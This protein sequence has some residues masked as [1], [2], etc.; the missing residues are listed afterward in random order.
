[1]GVS[2]MESESSPIK[3]SAI[4]LSRLISS[5]PIQGGG[6]L[7]LSYTILQLLLEWQNSIGFSGDL[8]EV[9]VWRGDTL[10]LLATASV[11]GQKTIGVDIG[12]HWLNAARNLITE[13]CLGL[14]VE[15]EICC[16]QGSS[17]LPGLGALIKQEVGS[18]D[19]RF[20][21]IDGEHSRD[22]AISDARTIS[23]MMA[24]WGLICFDDCFL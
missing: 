12:E 7:T 8:L 19:I 5:G 17:T 20:A 3:A 16:I 4:F 6:A 24:P 10:T 18:A 13:T 9:G 23:P 21:H 22:L 11:H 2:A 14:G 1:M 15:P